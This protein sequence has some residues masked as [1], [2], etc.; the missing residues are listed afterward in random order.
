ME[1]RYGPN[2]KQ[3][4]PCSTHNSQGMGD[5]DKEDDDDDDDNELLISDRQKYTQLIMDNK[6][7]ACLKA[8][9]TNLFR[10]VNLFFN[11]TVLLTPQYLLICFTNMV[12][13]FLIVAQACFP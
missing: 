5:V 6:H 10:V 2:T 7:T 13:L 12:S 3:E 11:H 9:H 1:L 4:R 8:S